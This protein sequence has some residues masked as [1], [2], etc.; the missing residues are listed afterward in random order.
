MRKLLVATAL[1]GGMAYLWKK[2]QMSLPFKSFC[3]GQKREKKILFVVTSHGQLG[4]SGTHTGYYLSEVSHTWKVLKMAGYE[5]D[6]VSPKGGTP[7]VDGFNLL[8][9]VNRNFWN[10]QYYQKKM[11]NSLT[12][13]EVNPADYAAI[14]Y[15]GGHG[16]MWDFPTEYSIKTIARTIYEK[17]GVVAAVCHGP[18]G[19][20]D[21]KLSDGT[22]LIAG[23]R[24][25]GFSNDEEKIMKREEIVP[26]LL[27][28]SLKKRDAYYEKGLPM[29]PHVVT[30]GRL[31][32]G[33]NPAS[34]FQVGIEIVKLLDFKPVPEQM[35]DPDS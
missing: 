12:P 22:Y 7:P 17:G 32:T 9:P 2:K 14:F 3:K 10:N 35:V 24:V 15:A 26:F 31:V 27:E 23:K 25:T 30:D 21:L 28:D 29:M 5:I 34:A 6:F 16:A 13:S 4:N 33:Q 18:A 8:D 11:L 1:L 19:L 20:V